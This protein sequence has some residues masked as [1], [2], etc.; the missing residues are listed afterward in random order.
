MLGRPNAAMLELDS[1]S[2]VLATP[3]MRLQQ[4]EWPVHLAALSLYFD[5]ARVAAARQ[6]LETT[7]LQGTA[8]ARALYALGRDA[9]VHGDTLR[10]AA[11]QGQLQA[12]GATSP[13]ALRHAALLGAELVAASDPRAALDSSAV[14]YIR[15]TTLVH[16]SPFAR[17]TTYLKRGDWQK[18]LGENDAVDLEWRWYENSDFEG[19]PSGP[20]Q[21]GEIDAILSVYARML[22]G[23]LRANRADKAIACH[24]LGRVKQLWAEVEPGMLPLKE[25]ARRAR[26][27]A[28]C[29]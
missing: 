19:W 24:H 3:E 22:R 5:T 25:R 1:A 15:D 2:E 28:Q 4:R 17:A 9:M 16:L 27:L 11:L 21:E 23:E 7:P 12:L 6:W 18:A 10:G 14:I 29:H 26:G 20:P 8:R 13:S